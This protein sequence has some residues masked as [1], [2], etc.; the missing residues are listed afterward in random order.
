[1][2]LKGSAR[3]S[4][5]ILTSCAQLSTVAE[6]GKVEAARAADETL[7]TTEWALCNAMTIGAI[8]REFGLNPERMAAFND[9]C[10]KFGGEVVLMAVP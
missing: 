1:M 7:R 10:A 5:I 6:F 3:L 8:R 9:L 4:F 2:I